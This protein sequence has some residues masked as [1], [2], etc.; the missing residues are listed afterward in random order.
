MTAPKAEA[1][2]ILKS[3]IASTKALIAKF[4]TLIQTGALPNVPFDPS[5]PNA[6][7][8]YSDAGAILKAQT[9]KLSLLVLNKPYTPSEI[10]FI[11]KSLCQECIPALVSACQL[12]PPERYTNFLHSTIRESVASAFKHYLDLLEDIPVDEWGIKNIRSQ[13]T[14]RNTGVIWEG[15]DFAIKLAPMGLVAVAV[16]KVEEYHDLFKDAIEEL[17]EWRDGNSSMDIITN[18]LSE[19]K[20]IGAGVKEKVGAEARKHDINNVEEFEDNPF[21]L[22]EHASAAIMPVTRRAIETLKL[23]RLL[24]PALLKRRVKRFPS[25]DAQTPPDKFPTAEQADRYDKIMLYCRL[26]GDDADNLA[27]A[28]YAQDVEQVNNSL[29]TIRDCARKCVA[30]AEKTWEGGE[31]EFTKW[32][33]TW[34]VKLDEQ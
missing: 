28:L 13:K 11:L 21:N 4:E 2:A 15:M 16:T 30:L 10:T 20:P 27:A 17:E 1:L 26:F 29:R 31:D 3:T 18:N 34:L 32:V 25:I 33:R 24:Y 5:S 9:T 23:I 22:P 14:L 12:C 19:M 6:V 7:A 8:L